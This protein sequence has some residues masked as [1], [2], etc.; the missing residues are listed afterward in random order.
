MKLSV[1]LFP[2]HRQL[3]EGTLTPAL[4]VEGFQAEGIA[5]LEPMMSH[6]RADLGK[7]EEFHRAAIEAG[8]VYSCC[9][10][11]VNLVGEN[12]G[13][14]RAAL[15]QVERDVAFCREHLGCSLVLLAG[16][17]PSAGMSNADGR[18]LYAEQLARARERTKGSG[19]TLTIEDFGVYPAFTAAGAHCLEVLEAVP[20][21]QFTFDNGNFLFADDRPTEVFPLFRGRIGHVHIKDFARCGPDEQPALKS[22]SGKGYCGCLI[23]QGEAE[24]AA[25]LKLLKANCY[26]GWLSLEVGGDP[27]RETFEGARFIRRVWGEA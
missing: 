8:M 17:K 19:I 4:L 14:R 13:D 16:T 3:M 7:W 21:L 27:L 22:L 26:E 15:D 10:I 2:F 12:E 5:A 11:G 25:T 18:K 24:V 6:R 1:M 20:E 9:D 23:G